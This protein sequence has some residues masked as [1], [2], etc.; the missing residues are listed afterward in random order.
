MRYPTGSF[1]FLTYLEQPIFKFIIYLTFS[2]FPGTLPG[3]NMFNV[4]KYAGESL[5][6]MAD[7]T[8]NILFLIPGV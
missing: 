2:C 8:R 5:A 3:L 7:K 4:L 6:T 1:P